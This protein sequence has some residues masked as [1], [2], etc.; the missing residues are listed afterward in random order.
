LNDDFEKLRKGEFLKVDINSSIPPK[1]TDK[2]SDK[3]YYFFK[4]KKREH[5]LKISLKDGLGILY[6]I[7]LTPKKLNLSRVNLVEI[8]MGLKGIVRIENDDMGLTSCIGKSSIKFYS[9]KYS[10]FKEIYDC[11]VNDKF[12]APDYETTRSL[13]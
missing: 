2:I 3:I 13:K 1:L 4:R 11:I 5:S 8:V 9:E 7:N 6:R 10:D 12:I